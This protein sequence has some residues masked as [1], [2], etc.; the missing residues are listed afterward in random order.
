M[1]YTEHIGEISYE[2]AMLIAHVRGWM[3]DSRECALC[4]KH[5]EKLELQACHQELLGERVLS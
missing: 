5:K 3:H 2:E 4:L 1:N